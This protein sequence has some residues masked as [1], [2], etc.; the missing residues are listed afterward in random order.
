MGRQ[1]VSKRKSK[2]TNAKPM[3]GGTALPLTPRVSET[4]P[5]RTVDVGKVVTAHKSVES[6]AAVGTRRAKKG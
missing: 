1:G 6:P 3:A 4:Q 5:V 2:Q